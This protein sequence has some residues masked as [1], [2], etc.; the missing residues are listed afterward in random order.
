MGNKITI[1]NTLAWLICTAFFMYEFALRTV[2]GTLQPNIMADFHLTSMEFSVLSTTSYQLIYGVMQI[3]VGVC[4]DRFGLKYSL[5]C[6]VVLCCITSLGFSLTHNFHM[7]IVYRLLMGLGS[8]F[9][10]VCLLVT[11][12]DRMPRKNIA[13]FLGIS[14][15]MGTIGPIL[16]AG[17]LSTYALSASY[18]WRDLFYNLSLVA[19]FLAVLVFLF[20]DK[21]RPAS[22]EVI[23]LTRPSSITE[24]LL[25]II[26][27]KQIWLI[28]LF[29]GS[30]YFS[31]E[32]F[33]EN[34]GISFLSLKGVSPVLSSYM[35]SIAWFGYAVGC[36]ILGFLS[37]KL[38][39]R[40]PFIIGSAI[41]AFL[42]LIDIVYLPPNDIIT[43]LC[44][45]LL[46]FGVSASTIGFA[47]AA[48]QAKPDNL[49]LVLGFNNMMVVAFT[50]LCTV[51]ITSALTHLAPSH[52]LLDL[53]H[54]KTAFIL[55][56]I[57][58]LPAIIAS[59]KINETFCKS[60]SVHTKLIINKPVNESL[61]LN[62]NV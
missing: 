8:A 47:M 45:F 39:R 15:F 16:A 46:G 10:F 44:F 41:I 48:E 29:S 53:I 36:P 23:I 22:N 54:Y 17:P 34:E 51:T 27:N 35:I 18:N 13:A 56:I 33:S 5:F 2:M 43:S 9:G 32:Y 12:Y 38:E 7:A 1:K 59:I 24:K 19:A 42:S 58:T 57:F 4:I 40:K 20:L 55:A 31:V 11:I 6:A 3:L 62:E 49:A 28:A 61:V 30:I 21:N 52:Y 50:L 25:S 14:Q 26:K 60:R 37:D